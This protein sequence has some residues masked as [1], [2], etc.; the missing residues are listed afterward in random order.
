M[1][2]KRKMVDLPDIE[3]IDHAALSLLSKNSLDLSLGL[4]NLT[5]DQA[6]ILGNGFGSLSLPKISRLMGTGKFDSINKRQ[7]SIKFLDYHRDE[8]IN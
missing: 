8:I 3:K 7:G 5:L 2:N 1:G 4:K 6:E